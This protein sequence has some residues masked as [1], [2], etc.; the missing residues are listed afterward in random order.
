MA[1]ESDGDNAVTAPA[2]C[3]H[4]G[5]DVPAGLR[6]PVASEQFCCAGC[7]TVRALL[8]AEGLGDYYSRR[9]AGMPA[10]PT[11]R[12]YDEL[13]DPKF[14]A[15]HVRV[16][17]A[18]TTGGALHR[19]E[20]MVSNMHCTACVWILERLPQ[21]LPGVHAVRVDL[22]RGTIGVTWDSSRIALSR[23]AQTIDGYGYPVHPYRAGQSEAHGRREERALIVRMGIAGACA[24]NVMLLATALYA[25]AFSTMGGSEAA[26]FR[27]ASLIVTTVAVFGPGLMFFR[28]ALGA[29]RA[30]QPHMDLPVSLGVAAGYLQGAVNTIRGTGEVYFDSVATLIFLLIVA[31]WFRFRQTRRA[32]S[33]TEAMAALT[34]SVARRVAQTANGDFDLDAPVVDVPTEAVVAGDLVEVR[35]GDAVPVDGVVAWGQCRLDTKI[36]TGESLPMRIEVGDRVEA[37]TTAVGGRI[38]VRAEASGE[39][40]RVAKLGELVRTLSARRAPTVELAHRMAGWFVVGAVGLA[41]ATALLWWFLADGSDGHAGA[42]GLDH[43][44]ALLIV[45]CPCALAMATPL[46]ISFAMGRGAKVGS[47]IKGGDALEALA[48]TEIAV[49]DKTGTLTDG[50]L[51]VI[52][53]HGDADTKEAVARL[54]AASA[55]PIARCLVQATGATTGRGQA[56]MSEVT[57]D[58]QGVRGEVDGHR[59]V[60]GAAAY[61]ADH[62]VLE[63]GH[64]GRVEALAQNGVTPVVVARDGGSVAVIGIGDSI[65]SDAAATIAALTTAGIE[66]WILS[67]DEPGVVGAV[68]SQLGIASANAHGHVSPEEKARIVAELSVHGTVAMIGDGVNDAPAMA[69]ARVGIAVRGSA[70][71]SLTAAD[72]YIA[73]EGL[74]PV[75]EAFAAGRDTLRV[76]HRNLVVSLFYNLSGAGLAMA[77]L[78][79]PLVAAILMPISS[80]SV[81]A[82]SVRNP[83]FD[84]SVGVGTWPS[85]GR[86]ARR[87]GPSAALS[88]VSSASVAVRPASP[89]AATMEIEPRQGGL[90]S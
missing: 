30:R 39:D 2:A 58:R 63:P 5:L 49:F 81:I 17:S 9:D 43:A 16:G 24:G 62:A 55:H 23:I 18:T 59:Y 3:A 33:A 41:M 65:R 68:A 71:A 82:S 35:G 53:W 38:I 19:V 79:H 75:A 13:D 4:C 44:I 77:G 45:T 10:S 56:T 27:W 57:V 72:L 70:E 54:E 46:A 12:T 67:G 88:A 61:V 34:P 11:G 73:G 31:R 85:L 84:R 69:A 50:R 6:D 86:G 60:V 90:R 76:I 52:E 78:L 32:L 83:A 20:L 64:R 51:S 8:L 48:H 89:N 14:V 40:T 36:L 22:G 26:L 74:A 66:V 1:T 25:G 42:R 37:G 28:G 7:K 80:V 47:L 29:L 87:R 21:A 15:R